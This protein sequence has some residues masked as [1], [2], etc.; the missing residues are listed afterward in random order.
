M[1]KGGRGLAFTTH[2]LHPAFPVD[3]S[4]QVDL[5]YSDH[6]A[7][8]GKGDKMA[9]RKKADKG[10]LLAKIPNVDDPDPAVFGN[11]Y[12]GLVSQWIHQDRLM[13]SRTQLVMALQV[14]CLGGGYAVS[15]KD[16]LLAT[17]VV[18]LSGVFSLAALHLVRIDRKDRDLAE[19]VLPWVGKHLLS[20]SGGASDTDVLTNLHLKNAFMMHEGETTR[21]LKGGMVLQIMIWV[22]IAVDALFI[23]RLWR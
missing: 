14:A 17:G 20:K 21:R 5:S 6:G 13:W 23:W 11:F 7:A 10:D 1:P 4:K 22:M 8:H 3:Y 15:H 16:R 12:R 9:T 19:A 2:S 18:V